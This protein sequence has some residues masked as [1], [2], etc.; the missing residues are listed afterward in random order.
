M[1]VARVGV[2]G[3]LAVGV[4]FGLLALMDLLIRVSDTGPAETKTIKIEDFV[5][6]KR[7]VTENV[8]KSEVEKPEDPAEPPPDLPDVDV[9]FDV[10][11]DAVA[12]AAPK[13]G[14]NLEVGLGGGFARDSD[15]IPVYVPQPNYPRRA[16]T[17]GKEG[18][19]VVQVIITTTGG[20][21]DPVLIEENPEGWGFGNAAIRAADKLKY[22]PRVVDGVAQEVPGVL[23]KFTFQMAK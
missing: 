21:R 1:A 10:P 22:N 2:A 20:V 19:A 14:G 15:Y 13:V 16:Q 3:V 12:I 5:E 6:V 18:Y 4:T 7:D 9:D 17:R 8:K 23:Y 11:D